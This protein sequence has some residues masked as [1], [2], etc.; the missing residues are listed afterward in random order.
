MEIEDQESGAED[1]VS[2]AEITMS[3]TALPYFWK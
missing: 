1:Y 2:E 3:A